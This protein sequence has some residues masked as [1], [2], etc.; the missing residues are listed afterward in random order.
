M[1]H[2]KGSWLAIAVA[3]G[4][5]VA[6][7]AWAQA[8]DAGEPVGAATASTATAA[9][10][11]TPQMLEQG[12]MS[13]PRNWPHYGGDYSNA[14]YSPLSTIN[15]TNVAT[16]VPRWAFQ[17]GVVASFENTP[18]VVDGTMYVT[19]PYNHAMAL[20]AR[21]GKKK[22]EYVHKLTG[23]EIFCCGPNN[24]GVAVYQEKVY[25]ATLDARLVALNA[26][27]GKVAW[28]VEIADPMAGYSE[29]MAPLATPDGK[30][31]IGTSGAEYGIRGFL[32][33]YDANSGKLLWT[34]YTIPSPQEGGWWGDWTNTALGGRE[35]LNRNI[36]QEKADSARHADAWT[37][38][39]GSIWMTPAYDPATKA[40][41]VAIGNPS[42][43]L[44]GSIRPGD[45]RWTEG[46]CSINAD[47]GKQ[48]WCTQYLPHDV[49]DLDAVSPV[50][51]FTATIGGKETLVA[52]HAGKTGWYYVFDRKTGKLLKRSQNY[53]PHENIFAQPTADGVRMLPG[54]NGGTEWSPTAYSPQTG[55]VYIQNLHQPMNYI[56]HSTPYEKGR[57]WLGSAFVAI[58][59]EDQW[60]NTVGVDPVS[61]RVVWEVRYDDPGIGGLLATAG[62][63][64]FGSEGSGPIAAYDAKS[65]TKLWAFNAGAGCNSAPMAY[66]LDGE[67]FI[68]VAC[69]GNFQLNYPYGNTL[70]VF[71]LP[72]RYMR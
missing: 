58:P 30:I 47:T 11:A 54:A 60:G 61:G 6:P 34:W 49:W 68:A 38:G 29:T 16:L 1:S 66:E 53:V 32:K 18:I 15:T 56:V 25:M 57:L 48:N 21:T 51:L 9:A 4:L 7:V 8:P 3:A 42:P 5:V 63:L 31:L 22:W 72:K 23:D 40:V 27:D 46:I 43:D 26:A 35:S 37:R 59:D 17:T 71:G 44:D 50:V 62:G 69:G 67:Q 41:F 65:G 55:Y 19:T 10:L 39:G 64:V 36:R 12:H 14:R 52:G 24:R 20:D 2:P 70:Y 33:A 45:N 28:D 13:N